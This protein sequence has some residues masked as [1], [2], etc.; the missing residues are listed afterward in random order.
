MTPYW[1]LLRPTQWLKNIFILAGI[2]FASAWAQADKAQAALLLM[3]GFCA[4]ASSV[5]IFNDYRDQAVDRHHPR[6]RFRPLASGQIQA[7]PAL[8]LAFSLA[9]ASVLLAFF[10]SITAGLLFLSYLVLNTAY[11]LWLKHCMGWDIV[12][13]ALGFILRVLVGTIGIAIIPSTWLLLCSFC[14]ALTLAL[15][16][17]RAELKQL[18]HQHISRRVLLNYSISKIDFFLLASCLTTIIIYSVYLEQKHLFAQHLILAG[19]LMLGLVVGGFGRYLWLLYAT[20]RAENPARLVLTDRVLLL[21]TLLWIGMVV[22]Y[23]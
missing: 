4:L 18:D 3:L 17:R 7:L 19:L 14:L 12:C 8:C 15:G 2:S 11:S 22:F 6:K 21:L 16:K 9:V 1:R 23:V 13:I 20:D 10:I 5:Y